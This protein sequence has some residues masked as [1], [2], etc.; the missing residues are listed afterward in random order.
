MNTEG[1]GFDPTKTAGIAGGDA[2]RTFAVYDALLY[3]DPHTG[4][5]VPETL[6]SMTTTDGLVWTMKV[7][8]NIKFTDQTPYDAA[9]IQFNWDRHRDPANASPQRTTVNTF[10][11]QVVDPLTLKVTL[12]A[13]N[14]QFP[15]LISAGTSLSYIGS[16][17]AIQTAGS[18]YNAKPVG[19]GPFMLKEWV[20][21]DHMTM[22]RNPT[23]WNAPRPYLDSIT[24]RPIT[25]ET[26]RANSFK[27]GEGQLQ[28]TSTAATVTSE[29]GTYPVLTAPSINSS[30]LLFNETKAPFNDPTVRRAIQLA[31]DTDQINKTLF[32]GVYETPKGFFP[33]TYPYADPT[34]TFPTP[35]LTQAQTLIDNYVAKNGGADISFSWETSNT[36]QNQ[37]VGQLMQAQVQRLKHVT[38]TFKFVTSNQIV[39]DQLAKN[40]D[41]ASTVLNGVDPEPQFSET[42]LSKG[43]RNVTGYSSTAF[44]KAIADSRAALDP[45]SR[46]QALK[47]AQRIAIDDV[48]VIVLYRAPIFWISTPNIRDLDTFDEG[49]LLSDRL[50]IKTR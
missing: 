29:A 13:P 42:L 36:L 27:A 35:D 22:V 12:T 46:V 16:P 24:F 1:N 43:S 4:G 14:G 9:A 20:R 11:T 30:L 2:Q 23:Y 31:I 28:Y 45:A 3:Q 33:S 47:A 21:D 19:A 7:R 25:D 18:N 8:P 26:Q 32:G 39:V 6:A 5:V 44:D 34:L 41:T 40:Y 37:Q 15:R 17:T 10:S 38:M 50:W 49:G 48:P